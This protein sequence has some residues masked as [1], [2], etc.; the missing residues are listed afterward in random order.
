VFAEVTGLECVKVECAYCH[1]RGWTLT[2]DGTALVDLVQEL[3][4]ELVQTPKGEELPF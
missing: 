4:P 2:G 3:Y 1:S